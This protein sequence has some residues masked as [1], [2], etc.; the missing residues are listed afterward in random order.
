MSAFLRSILGVPFCCFPC[1]GNGRTKLKS[2]Q[3]IT[4]MFGDLC[5]PEKQTCPLSFLSTGKSSTAGPKGQ[6][7]VPASKKRRPSGIFKRSQ[8]MDRHPAETLHVLI[9]YKGLEIKA[10]SVMK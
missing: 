7:K 6:Q 9:H 5:D 10:Q 4:S 8:C 3:G 2:S 1:F